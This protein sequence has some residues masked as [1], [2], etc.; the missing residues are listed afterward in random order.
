MTYFY[1]IENQALR[2]YPKIN[3]HYFNIFYIFLGG[4]GYNF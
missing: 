3:L 4:R 1:I 2:L